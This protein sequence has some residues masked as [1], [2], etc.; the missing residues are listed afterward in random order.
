MTPAVWTGH[1]WPAQQLRAFT[2]TCPDEDVCPQQVRRTAKSKVQTLALSWLVPSHGSCMEGW[3][4]RR[5]LFVSQL[6]EPHLPAL[7]CPILTITMA[8]GKPK[9]TKWYGL[10]KASRARA[11]AQVLWSHLPTPSPGCGTGTGKRVLLALLGEPG[12]NCAEGNCSGCAL[13]HR[14]KLRVCL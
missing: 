12:L 5:L 2:I 11:S 13:C 4:R 1:E 3:L 14:R 7:P 6:A 9:L 10:Q 8:A